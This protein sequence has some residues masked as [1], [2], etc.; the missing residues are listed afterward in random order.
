M[1]APIRYRPSNGT[2]GDCFIAR[3]CCHCQH[4]APARRS[5]GFDGCDILARTF[6]LEITDPAYPAEWRADGPS[7]PRCTA[8]LAEGDVEPLDPVAALRL[9]L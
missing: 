5:D 3:W 7:G 1:T 8:F 9:L 4:D 6:A 2:E